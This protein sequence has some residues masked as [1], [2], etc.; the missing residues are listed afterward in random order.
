VSGK[1]GCVTVRSLRLRTGPGTDRS[2]IGSLSRG[3]KLTILRKS[4]KWLKVR[5]DDKTGFVYARYV[6]SLPIKPSHLYLIEEEDIQ[7]VELAPEKPLGA[8][9]PASPGKKLL[10]RTWNRFGGL[11]EVLCRKLKIDPGV[12]LAVLCVESRGRG[13]G[14]DGR[15]II[16]FENHVFRRYWGK[17]HPDLFDRHFKLNRQKPW[18]GHKFRKNADD[19]WKSVHGRGQTGEWEAFEFARSKHRR[20]SLYSI[21][22]GLP[23]IMGFNHQRAG[24]RSVRKMFDS[25]AKSERNQIIG[26]FDFI[27]ESDSKLIR[28]LKKKDLL[29][30]AK[31]YNGPGKANAISELIGNYR[32][33]F[34]ELQGKKNIDNDSGE[35]ILI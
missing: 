9:S 25:F 27:R 24:Y 14:K 20:F 18:C 34:E 17:S 32:L 12:A 4:G 13:F 22:M 28:A 31:L 30:F 6:D 3:T 16:R 11:L 19:K 1:K 8:I 26:L 5:V 21:S 10:K 2:I 33:W 35:R 7:K 23:Q 29:M 15:M